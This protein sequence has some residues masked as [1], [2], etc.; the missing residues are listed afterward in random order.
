MVVLD[1]SCRSCLRFWSFMCEEWNGISFFYND[2]IESS[3]CL[4]LFTDVTTSVGF[5]GFYND[6][7]FSRGLAN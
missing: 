2:F 4:Q 3:D 1:E 7:W 5:G 6:E